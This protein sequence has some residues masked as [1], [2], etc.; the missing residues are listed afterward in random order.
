MSNK[1]VTKGE[2]ELC[3]E[4]FLLDSD[5]EFFPDPFRY[6]DLRLVHNE[7]VSEI[8]KNLIEIMIKQRISYNVKEHYDWDVPKSNYVIRQGCSFHP[9]DVIVF[10]FILNRLVPIIEPN[11]SKARYSYKVKNPKLKHLFGNRPTE[12]WIKFKNDIRD[13]FANNPE[14]KYL[15]STDVAGFFEY[16]P[17]VIFKKQ[18]LQMCNN[19]EDKAIELLRVMLRTYSVSKYS[20]MPQN[21]EPFS[22]LCTAF[23]DFLDKELEAN[24]LKHFRYVDD[25]KVACK[26]KKDAKK[27]IV[28]IIR[29]L[30][31]AHLNLSTAKTDII[32]KNSE[33]FNDIIKDFPNLLY[34]IDKAINRK[35]KRII[36]I[37]FPKLIDLTLQVMKQVKKFDERLFRAC[38]WR[39][40]KIHYF[41]NINKLNIDPVGKACLKLMDSMPSRSDTFLRFLVL[42]KDRKYV[43]DG[44]Y[45]ILQDCVYPWQE[46]HVWYLLIQ[47]DK[48]KNTDILNLAK[49]RA[50][51]NGYDEAS[52]NYIF[53]F[54]GKHGDYQDRQYLAGRFP[55]TQ[56]FRAKRSIIIAIQEYSDRNTI[57]NEILRVKNDLIL[58][59]LV[60][61]IKQL[62]NPEYVSVNKNIGSDVAI[63]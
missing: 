20:G 44:L 12:N 13:Y 61:Y 54:L 16:I 25:I 34:D 63:S 47:C 41:K 46:M 2:I 43:Q 18:L 23:L 49:Q 4:R 11:L 5:D 39:I 24:S 8:H 50:R 22:Y 42:H 27:A 3:F 30:R 53:I 36:N 32:P 56:S 7:I 59:S 10:H 9:Y 31:S 62:N 38:I 1:R 57:Y 26:T 55:F 21:C 28:Q 6:K 58:V 45:S 51:D 14:Y 40:L 17:I 37:L 19:N 15:V 35:Q 29:S 33:K 52:R 48:I 60:K